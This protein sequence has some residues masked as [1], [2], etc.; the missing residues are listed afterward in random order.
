[1]K[2]KLLI[3]FLALFLLAHVPAASAEIYKWVDTAGEKHFTDDISKVPPEYRN[4]VLDVSD[5]V[6]ERDQELLD[7]ERAQQM[8]KQ[9]EL[10]PPTP[11]DPTDAAIQESLV[12]VFKDNKLP[13]P[14]EE[15]AAGFIKLVRVWLVPLLLAILLI[16]G[17]GVGLTIHAM[18]NNHWAWVAGSLGWLLV[19]FFIR[20]TNPAAI[21][22]SP[23]LWCVA[24]YLYVLPMIA[25]PPFN[26]GE[27]D[28]EYLRWLL[29]TL[30]VAATVIAVFG[31]VEGIKW[32][33]TVFEARDIALPGME[34]AAPTG[35]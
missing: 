14:S 28:R 19:T 29:P 32:T 34:A 30:V 5:A 33:H 10:E 17:M 27:D 9:K 11:E 24:S 3:A 25:Y 18:V 4:Q 35:N 26:V 12:R 31:T 2:T 22:Q 1:M 7:A 13:L 15:E 20:P 23:F 8:E 6:R 21:F 16:L